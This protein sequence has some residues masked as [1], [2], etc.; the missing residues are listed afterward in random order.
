[1]DTSQRLAGHALDPLTADEIRE[2]A[3]ILGRDR[4][5]APPRWRFASIEL[6]EPPKAMLGPPGGLPRR[7]ALA[8]CWNR[9]DGHAY[10]AVISLADGAVTG[11][12]EL[13]GQ[14]PNMTVDE[15]HECDEM[16]RAHPKLIAALARRGIT[17]MTLVLTDTWA[18]GAALVPELSN[19][20]SMVKEI[21]QAR[22]VQPFLTVTDV[23]N[24]SG[25][26]DAGQALMKLIT[27]RSA[28]FTL[29]GVGVFAGARRRITT[30]FRRNAN[31][32][33]M[34]A[35]WQEG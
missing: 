33:S 15:W 18:Y 20:T 3:A 2:V 19:D 31:G 13:P 9:E 4:G 12:E 1:M 23:G 24:L 6:I 27:T 25:M 5:V 32:T 30:T 14:Q 22:S 29:T 16:L 21:V 10:R 26:G 11:W 7:D 8:V 17:D 35:S 28:Y 34:L